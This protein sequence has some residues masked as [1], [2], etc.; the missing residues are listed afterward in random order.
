L[1]EGERL[2]EQ[3]RVQVFMQ[4]SD[5]LRA[6]APDEITQ[7]VFDT[8]ID[9]ENRFVTYWLT[10]EMRDRQGQVLPID[11]FKRKMNVMQKRH[12]PVHVGHTP[13]TV[14]EL[15]N[16]GFGLNPK[17]QKE[18]CWVTL[19]IFDDYPYDDQAWEKIQAGE[20]GFVSVGGEQYVDPVTGAVI[21]LAP[22]EIALTPQGAN[23]GAE[24][25]AVAMAKSD[26]S[27][28]EFEQ[29]R[30]EHPSF[31]DEQIKQIVADHAK[32]GKCNGL[33]K[34]SVNTETLKSPASMT[35]AGE[36]LDS[37]VPK[38]TVDA[39]LKK[40]ESVPA[41]GKVL[42]GKVEDQASGGNKEF[43]GKPVEKEFPPKEESK[44]EEPAAEKP[45]EAP[46]EVPAEDAKEEAVEEEEG[47]ENKEILASIAE[48][49]VA[50]QEIAALLKGAAAAGAPGAPEVNLVKTAEP[51]GKA[52]V[53]MALDKSSLESSVTP[54]PM[55]SAGFD[56]QM[57][58]A[59]G[60][61][62]HAG[63]QQVNDARD[64]A[65]GRKNLDV[66]AAVS[67]LDLS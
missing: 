53:A 25:I 39:A 50:I 26:D 31:S 43:E 40:N 44:K 7:S 18:G 34:C 3:W 1:A 24:Q 27:Q 10:V 60:K 13:R 64:I 19:Y 47:V 59:V 21:D 49:K 35:K 14:G 52:A 45:A 57:T 62:P 9:S 65:M 42:E 30:K 66:L 15:N 38:E 28:S 56:P 58:P 22:C 33:S 2:K 48:M 54:R 55:S 63:N 61:G 46:A 51:L 6:P 41:A 36:D 17:F 5:I 37:I 32:L 29:E 12:A 11:L 4:K 8:I 23:E 67:S 20:Y 16:H